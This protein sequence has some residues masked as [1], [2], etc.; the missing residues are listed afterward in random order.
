MEYTYLIKSPLRE[1]ILEALE[2]KKSLR[3]LMERTIK[4]PVWDGREDKEFSE[5]IYRWYLEDIIKIKIKI[6]N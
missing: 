6:R 2:N 4:R 1:E 3:D 5:S